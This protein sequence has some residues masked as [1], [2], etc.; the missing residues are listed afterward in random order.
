MNIK[1]I[2]ILKDNKIYP[3]WFLEKGCVQSIVEDMEVK[4][5]CMPYRSYPIPSPEDL[6]CLITDYT[7]DGETVN[8]SC[9]LSPIGNMFYSVK[10]IVGGVQDCQEVKTNSP[11]LDDALAEA[12]IEAHGYTAD[13]KKYR[14]ELIN[15]L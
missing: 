9:K 12:L 1:N 2:K 14:E 15:K 4:E 6:M 11:F 10:A 8:V 13:K 3:R 5:Q 7:I